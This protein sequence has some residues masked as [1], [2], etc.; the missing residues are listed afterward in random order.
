MNVRII[1]D[2]GKKRLWNA[3]FQPGSAEKMS[4]NSPAEGIFP[5]KSEIP[6]AWEWMGFNESFLGL[7]LISLIKIFIGI[8]M[9][10][11]GIGIIKNAGMRWDL[12]LIKQQSNQNLG[13]IH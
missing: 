4:F 8:T 13:R 7:V 5:W 6:G 9:G 10:K 3:G 1:K 2:L 11:A 12:E